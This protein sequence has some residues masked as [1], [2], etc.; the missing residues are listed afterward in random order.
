MRI[1]T[2]VAGEAPI[3]IILSGSNNLKKRIIQFAYTY[4]TIDYQT[5]ATYAL[6]TSAKAWEDLQAGKGYIARYPANTSGAVVRSVYLAY[7]DS[8]DPQTY[9]QPVFVFEGDNGF[10]GYVPAVNSEWVE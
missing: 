8:F 9:L 4:W 5:S 10:L 1:L 7:Y 3:S 6:K 2:P